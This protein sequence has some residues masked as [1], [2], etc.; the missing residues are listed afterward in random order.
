MRRDL[1][2]EI[3]FITILFFDSL[4]DIKAA[5]RPRLRNRR[6]SAGAQATSVA[7]RREGRALR[8]ALH[9]RVLVIR[10]TTNATTRT[11]TRSMR[12]E[13]EPLLERGDE[14][15]SVETRLRYRIDRLIGQ[16]GYGQVYTA[17]RVG[18]SATVP[19]TVCIKV[20]RRIEAWIRE[21]YFGQLLDGHPRAIAIY[22]AFVVMRADGTP[23]YCLALE[24]ARQGDLSAF[25]QRNR[26]K[27]KETI[28]QARDRRHPAGARPAPSRAAAP[29]RP[30][31][32]QRLRLRQHPPQARRL[33]H[34]PRA[35][36]QAR[37]HR[38]H[39][40]PADGAERH[41]R[42]RGPEVAGA[43]RR[44][45]G[46]AAAGHADQ[47]RCERARSRARSAEASLLRSPQG[48]HLSLHRR[49]AQ[50]LRERR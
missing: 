48:D 7:I 10:H 29:S 8:R 26:R 47:G 45:S 15:A 49:A 33:R 28:A 12:A 50:A 3:E 1:G 42:R 16:G 30:D 14:I 9:Q 41:L 13:R 36:E 20:S 21:A 25:L 27:W 38:A 19:A 46:R 39:A 23:L 37:H 17:R 32:A 35:E 6:H 4:D 24:Y 18:R 5:D 43:R 34:R 11:R 31:A 2:H 22:D 40:E 44:V